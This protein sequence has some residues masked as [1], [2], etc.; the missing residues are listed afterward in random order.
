MVDGLHGLGHHAVVRCH[1]QNGDI[2]RVCTTHTHGGKSLMSGSIQESDGIA[3]YIH[4]I[5]TDVL[6]DT[7]GLPVGHIRM[8]DGIQ[9]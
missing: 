2:G 4:R 1:H 8:S 5:S 6:G 3:V 9:K 7:A